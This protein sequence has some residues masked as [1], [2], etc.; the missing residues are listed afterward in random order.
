[1]AEKELAYK[2]WEAK[3]DMVKAF[4][5][6]YPSKFVTVLSRFE[7]TE[8]DDGEIN[9]VFDWNTCRITYKS[10]DPSTFDLGSN[11]LKPTLSNKAF[12]YKVIKASVY[13]AGK[14]GNK[15]EGVRIRKD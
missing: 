10:S 3:Q 9:L 14:Y 4:R 7:V 13:G 15:W 12:S 8:A 2:S 5:Q 6:I 11:V 1:S